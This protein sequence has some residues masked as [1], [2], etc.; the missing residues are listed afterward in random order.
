MSDDWFVSEFGG[1]EVVLIL[2]GEMV[3]VD[4]DI[5]DFVF[6]EYDEIVGWIVFEGLFIIEIGWLV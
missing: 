5:D 4:V 1:F 3:I 6:M 2:V